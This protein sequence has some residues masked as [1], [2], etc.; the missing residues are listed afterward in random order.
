MATL[1]QDRI[2]EL[3][4]PYYGGAS[5]RMLL[6]LSQYL[7][8]LVKW[9][10]RMNLTAIRSPEEMV[11][12]HFGESLFLAS[13]LP[14]EAVTLLDLG[15]G[16]GFPGLPVQLARPE[17]SVTM[18]ESQSKKSAFLLEA[19]RVLGLGCEVW[20]RRVEE[21]PEGRQ[22]DVV[23]MRGVDRPDEAL[24]LG[25]GRVASGGTLALLTTDTEVE[26]FRVGIPGLERSY[27]HLIRV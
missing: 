26:G 12:R 20:G 5:E 16:A 25:R 10:A 27:L 13:H 24:V 11:T 7:D 3:I 4:A 21:M 9:N 14:A 22:F 8:L 6:Q 2:G 23:A 15:S 17:L 18:A 19:I 1:T